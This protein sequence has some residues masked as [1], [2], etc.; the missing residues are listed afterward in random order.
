M[1]HWRAE[2]EVKVC[3]WVPGPGSPHCGATPGLTATGHTHTPHTWSA[4]GFP[5][6]TPPFPALFT[7]IEP[8]VVL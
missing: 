5:C 7:Y 6:P 4:L 1:S 8:E 2:D 3:R